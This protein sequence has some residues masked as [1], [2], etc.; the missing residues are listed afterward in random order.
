MIHLDQLPPPRGGIKPSGP[1]PKAPGIKEVKSDATPR[2]VGGIKPGTFAP[3]GGVKSIP[4]PVGGIKSAETPNGHPKKKSKLAGPLSKEKSSDADPVDPPPV[5]PKKPTSA[6]FYYS[7]QFRTAVKSELGDTSSAADVARELGR[8]WK[9]MSPEAK[10][11]FEEQGKQDRERY[12]AEMKEY[13]VAMDKY[14]AAHPELNK[15]TK[16]IVPLFNKVVTIEGHSQDKLFYVLTYLPDLQWCHCVPLEQ[17]GVFDQSKGDYAGKPKLMLMPE[18]EGHEVDCSAAVCTPI[19][20]KLLKKSDDA[21]KEEWALP[22][23]I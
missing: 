20:V 18:G 6:F 5:Q 9:E 19:K 14:N 10:V 2:A 3:V 1:S 23:P 17:R 16:K 7:N 15:K 22:L 13:K 21:D 8:R 12:E 11:G 4:V